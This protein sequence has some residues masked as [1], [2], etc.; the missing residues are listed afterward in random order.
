MITL[1]ITIPEDKVVE[2]ASYVP[3]IGGEVNKNN[4]VFTAIKPERDEDEVTHESFFG[5]N[6]KRVIRAFK[7]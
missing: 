2:V 6:I 7:D 5:E 4:A 1:K 3:K